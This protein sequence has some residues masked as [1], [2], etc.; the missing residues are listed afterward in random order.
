M[1]KREANGG[2][3]LPTC[4]QRSVSQGGGHG[5]R[6]SGRGGGAGD[7]AGEALGSRDP[8]AV[9][10]APVTCREHPAGTRAAPRE[11]GYQEGH[12]TAAGFSSIRSKTRGRSTSDRQDAFTL[13]KPPGL[14]CR[15]SYSETFTKGA[16]GP[17]SARSTSRT[18]ARHHHS[19]E[20]GP[21]ALRQ[22]DQSVPRLPLPTRQGGRPSEGLRSLTWE[23][24]GE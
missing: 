22:E 20:T 17:S 6:T 4:A 13:Q 19:P 1:E 23:V 18:R 16:L 15:Q 8:R 24:T 3:G 9:P 7:T 14:L 12:G 2:W 21:G 5:R 10:T 11:P